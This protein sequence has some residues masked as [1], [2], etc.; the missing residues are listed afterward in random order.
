[1]NEKHSIQTGADYQHKKNGLIY[2]VVAI[3]EDR[4][5]DELGVF[6][7]SSKTGEMY[8]R[9]LFDFQKAFELVVIDTVNQPVVFRG[10]LHPNQFRFDTYVMT[11]NGEARRVDT[12]EVMIQALSEASLKMAVDLKEYT[13]YSIK[14]SL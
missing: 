11:Y 2:N 5:R 9:E 4:T 3:G 13:K 8:Y 10:T 7:T 14:P 6:Y 1:M 12:A